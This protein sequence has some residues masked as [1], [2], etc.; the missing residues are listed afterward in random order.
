MKSQLLRTR[1]NMNRNHTKFESNSD[2]SQNIRRHFDW[3]MNGSY[4]DYSDNT[5]YVEFFMCHH[6]TTPDVMYCTTT[7]L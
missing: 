1:A 6:T 3:Y 4:S 2:Q 5:I 7:C